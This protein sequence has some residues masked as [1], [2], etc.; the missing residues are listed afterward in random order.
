MGRLNWVIVGYRGIGG[1]WTEI[2]GWEFWMGIWIEIW[3]V[4]ILPES[5]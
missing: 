1:I 5:G 3:M 2:F 4:E